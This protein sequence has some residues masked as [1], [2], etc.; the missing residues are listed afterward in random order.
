MGTPTRVWAGSK[1]RAGRPGEAPTGPRGPDEITD[2]ALLR[3]AREHVSEPGM[4]SVV[5]AYCA[6]RPTPFANVSV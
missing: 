6:E 2:G 5:A 4:L 1:A 3:G